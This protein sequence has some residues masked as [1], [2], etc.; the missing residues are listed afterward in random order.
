MALFSLSFSWLISTGV[1]PLPYEQNVEKVGGGKY[2]HPSAP[3]I[4]FLPY[5][6]EL[7]EGREPLISQPLLG[8]GDP[9]S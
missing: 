7:C 5:E 8:E 3:G 6:W 4:E 1:E 2:S 9:C